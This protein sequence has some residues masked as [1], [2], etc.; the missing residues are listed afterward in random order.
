MSALARMT[1]LVALDLSFC[2]ALWPARAARAARAARPT[3][4]LAEWLALAT[5]ARAQRLRY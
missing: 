1:N 2:D 3:T 4:T 5:P